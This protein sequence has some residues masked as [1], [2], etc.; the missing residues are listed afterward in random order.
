MKLGNFKSGVPRLKIRSLE[1]PG[2]LAKKHVMLLSGHLQN[3]VA[4][5]HRPTIPER[6]A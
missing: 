5:F 4:V 2:T 1:L 6:M 3:N